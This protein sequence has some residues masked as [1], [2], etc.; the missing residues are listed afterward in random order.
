MKKRWISLLLVLLILVAFLP[1]S[2]LSVTANENEWDGKIADGFARGS[3]TK[4]DPFVVSTA[5]QLAFL[6]SSVESG[7]LYQGQYIRLDAD[8]N[9]NKLSGISEWGTTTIP[10]NEWTPIGNTNYPFLG[11]FD[12]S[13]HTISGVYINT[14][15]DYQGLFGFCSNSI[16]TNLHISDGY[17][18][19]EKYTGG[20]VDF[21]SNSAISNCTNECNISGK[22]DYVGG[23]IG[24]S[25]GTTITNCKNFGSIFGGNSFC[26]GI[27]GSI[28]NSAEIKNCHNSGAVSATAY[29]T[30]GI[31]G[32]ALSSSI[33][34]CSN[35]A[36]VTSVDY[37]SGIVGYAEETTFTGCSNSGA[38]QGHDGNK[39]S[40]FWA[41]GVAAFALSCTLNDCYNTGDISGSSIGGVIGYCDFSSSID[42]CYN[43]GNIVAREKYTEYAGGVAG[44]VTRSTV[45]NCYNTGNVSGTGKDTGGVVGFLSHNSTIDH[46]YNN[47]SI[48][49]TN[50]ATGGVVG[51]VDYAKIEKCCNTGPVYSL[52]SGCGGIVGETSWGPVTACFNVG[53]VTGNYDVGG[54]IGLAGTNSPVSTC[55]NCGNITGIEYPTG[56]IT[57]YASSPITDCYN[58]GS[59]VGNDQSGGVVGWIYNSSITN[60]YNIGTVSG[61]T[62]YGGIVGNIGDPPCSLLFCYYLDTSTLSGNNYGASRTDS[63]MKSASYLVGFDFNATWTMDGDASYP[64]PELIGM[65]HGD[66]PNPFNDVIKGKFYY[67]PVLWAFFHNPQITSGTSNTTFS[68]NMICSRAQIVTFLWRT[69]GSPAPLSTINPFYDIKANKYYYDAVLWATESGITSGTSST[70][71]SP[72]N[73]CTRAQVATFLWRFAGSPPP[74]SSINPFTD[75]PSGKYYTRAVL[76]AANNGITSGTTNTTFSPDEA[77]T[78]GQIVTFLYRYIEKLT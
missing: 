73:S 29:R 33:I 22:G 7:S 49:G 61:N 43:T 39:F 6:Q 77:C 26:A 21:A 10:E 60:C 52:D 58:T 11:C 72:N 12:G 9:L 48:R 74:A 54:I 4:S 56:G 23:V 41:G 76:W 8:I 20:V 68:P 53:N 36:V 75:V 78:R 14:G 19:G 47:G 32:N 50:N 18:S 24:F 30:G 65:N 55:Y 31:A 71:F 62:N 70:T 37:T 59:I 66:L 25:D 69:A 51:A 46:C 45:S 17:L 40:K 42:N 13:N 5:S 16:I 15:N 2:I 63:Q 38:I 64:Y 1:G 27:V 67:K 57:G 3:G 35:K 44:W 28:S 34:S